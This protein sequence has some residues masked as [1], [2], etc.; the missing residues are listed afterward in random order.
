MTSSNCC[1]LT[2][3]QTSQEAGKVAWYSHL[4]KNF[5]LF[6]VIHIVKGFNVVNE[7]DAFLDF[8]CF[9]YDPTDIGGLI[10]GSSVFSK[11]SLYFWKFMYCWSLAWRILS[12]TLLACEMSTI[13][14]QFEHSLDVYI[15]FYFSLMSNTEYSTFLTI[16]FSPSL[17]PLTSSLCH[18]SNVKSIMTLNHISTRIIS[19]FT[20]NPNFPLCSLF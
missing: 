11:S 20:S 3:I 9:F 12:I 14:Q 1:L 16:P 13:M 15:C 2:C 10:S 6:V 17:D 8:S 19:R 5:P 4:L 7:A 18:L